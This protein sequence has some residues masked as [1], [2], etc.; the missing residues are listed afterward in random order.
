MSERH[1]A[2]FIPG[3][4][5]KVKAMES[6]TSHWLDHGLEP[7]VHCMH[8]RD[9]EPFQPK[10]L[11]LLKIIDELKNQDATVSVIG[12][13]AGGSAAVN[14]F[15]QRSAKIHRAINVCGRVRV[16]PTTGFRSFAAKTKTSP[17][18]AESVVQCERD[19][20]LLSIDNAKKI[21][22]VRPLFGDELVP[23]ETVSLIGAKNIT[24]PSIE[25]GLSIGAALTI[26]SGALIEF[27][28]GD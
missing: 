5:D 18:F 14:A 21:M 23:A 1:I 22:T 16:G 2:I 19:Q 4:G 25:H 10:L 15:M 8:W 11:Q 24:V 20:K 26:F 9:G 7:L 17:A 6:A 28:Q 12:T 3:L 13:S 27:L